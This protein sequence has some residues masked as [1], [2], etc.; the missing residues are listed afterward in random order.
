MFY[1]HHGIL[2]MFMNIFQ[3]F[4]SPE[5]GVQQLSVD[6]C[7][8]VTVGRDSTTPASF[9]LTRQDPVSER[10]SV[11]WACL[12]NFRDQFWFTKGSQGNV[13]QWAV[14]MANCF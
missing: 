13:L 10:L 2:N 7:G 6:G 4:W 3:M 5:L 1:L 8:G 9:L 12:A 11:T 14:R